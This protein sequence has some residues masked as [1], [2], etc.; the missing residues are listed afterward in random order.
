MTSGADESDRLK[1]ILRLIN[2]AKNAVETDAPTDA[3]G[4]A[5]ENFHEEIE[6]GEPDISPTET[7]RQP[8]VGCSLPVAFGFGIAT[9]TAH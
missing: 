8:W 5:E 9:P 7:A 4:V 3:T 6:W 1:E 2:G